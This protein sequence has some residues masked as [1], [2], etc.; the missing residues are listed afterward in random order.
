MSFVQTPDTDDM[1]FRP[2]PPRP[3]TF[4]SEAKNRASHRV[5]M[6]GIEVF[7]T[8]EPG[9]FNVHRQAKALWKDR[10]SLFQPTK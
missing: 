8:E 7:S 5:V 3:T 9:T 2:V 4:S 1:P 10:I 6:D